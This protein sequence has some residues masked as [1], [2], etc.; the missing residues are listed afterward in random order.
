ML[1]NS[2]INVGGQTVNFGA[3]GGD[4]AR[5]RPDP[6]DGRYPQHD[7]ERR[8]TARRCCV[9]RRRDGHGR[10]PAAARHRRP[11]RRRRH[12]PGH[13]ADAARRAEP[14]D[15]PPASRP[16]S[17][18]STAAD[19]LPPG[20]H[21]EKIYDRTE[22]INVTTRT[23]LHNMIFGIVL[24]FLV[25]WLFL[26]NLRSALIVAA[27]IPF[28]LFFAVD[29]PGA[30][31]RVG[32]SAVGRR[33]RFRPHRRRHR[34]HGREHL[35][36][37]ARRPGDERICVPEGIAA[38]APGSRGK[39]ADDR[40]RRQPRST[41]RSSSRP[42]SSSPAS[43]RCSPCRGVEG[44]IFGPMAQDLCLCHR[45]RPDRD[46]HRVAGAERR[47]CCRTGSRRPRPSS[48]AACAASIARSSNSR[49]PTAS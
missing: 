14:A 23:V 2:N 22:L 15:D 44:H 35:P 10:P 3:A 13:R 31:R 20:V 49:W 48:S 4:R 32:Q 47:C 24:I 27:T 46:L 37:S 16:R 40:Q 25:Q 36:P 21:I 12:R 42:R 7:G 29:H 1:N 33:D 39:F 26:G 45:R 8:T 17:R 41:G 38:G 6:L 5:R 43:C 11:G 30:A 34:D 28:A 19:I 18:R 9:K